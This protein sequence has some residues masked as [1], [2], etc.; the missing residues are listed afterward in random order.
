MCVCFGTILRWENNRW[1]QCFRSLTQVLTFFSFQSVGI[2][3]VSPFPWEFWREYRGLAGRCCFQ[4]AAPL[5]RSLLF[6]VWTEAWFGYQQVETPTYPSFLSIQQFPILHPRQL[7]SK[8][9]LF[10][11]VFLGEGKHGRIIFPFPLT[12]RIGAAQE[13]DHAI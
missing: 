11:K 12:S 13:K 1:S 10:I 3:V 2:S 5:I 7:W 8:L 6:S 9:L 4:W